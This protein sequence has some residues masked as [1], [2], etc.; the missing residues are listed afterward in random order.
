MPAS[1]RPDRATAD[2]DRRRDPERTRERI[3]QA[4]IEEFA[5]RGYAGARVSR[6]AA[7]AGVNAQLISYY[8]DGKAGLHQALLG[9]WQG[10]AASINRP[11]RALDEIAAEFVRASD[12]NRAFARLLAWESL[13]DTPTSRDHPG[14]DERRRWR[15]QFF[16]DNV[17]DLRQRQ[18]TGEI[19]ADLDPAH[20]LLALFAM[21]SAPTILPQ[22]VEQILDT[23]PDSEQFRATYAEQ[24][25]R[26]VR[27]LTRVR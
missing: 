14:V 20:L 21:S 19:P 23:D 10:I 27:H 24:V 5:E 8:F 13:G 6:I 18:E 2:S 25:A 9:R 11:G 17:E 15:S 7:S 22:V 4:A 1:K 3:L 16:S 12:R 26:I